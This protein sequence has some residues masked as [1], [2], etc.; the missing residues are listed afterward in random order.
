MTRQIKFRAWH[1]EHK[2]FIFSEDVSGGYWG[3][4]VLDCAEQYEPLQQFT[5]LLDKN[6]KEIY[7]GDV[8]NNGDEGA[9]WSVQWC[10]GGYWC[11]CDKELCESRPVNSLS[12]LEVIGNIYQNPELLTN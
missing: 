9:N 12:L 1:K 8:L 4:C 10:E 6:G 11:L 2:E 5:G 3:D 7:E